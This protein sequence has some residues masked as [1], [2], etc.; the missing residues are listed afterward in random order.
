MNQIVIEGRR[1]ATPE[2]F[3][4]EGDQLFGWFPPE[5]EGEFGCELYWGEATPENIAAIEAAG[6]PIGTRVVSK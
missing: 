1:V 3:S 2:S 5:R 4:R 6:I